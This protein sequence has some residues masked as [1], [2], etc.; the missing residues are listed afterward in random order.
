MS[1]RAVLVSPAQVSGSSRSSV[2]PY[3]LFSLV[4][5]DVYMIPYTD[6]HVNHLLLLLMRS[7]EAIKKAQR[8]YEKNTVERV[9][10][11]VPKGKKDL[12]QK[13]AAKNNESVNEML[14]RLADNEIK[15]VL[16]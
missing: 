16:G 2:L 4:I 11:R 8:E 3:Y 14:N 6:L 5:S 10:F 1:L 13:C 12:I 9:P 7:K 15:K